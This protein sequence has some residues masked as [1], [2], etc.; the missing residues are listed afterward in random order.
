LAGY[1]HIYKGF[2]VGFAGNYYNKT[3]T[4]TNHFRAGSVEIRYC[5]FINKQNAIRKKHISLYGGFA[6]S[7]YLFNYANVSSSTQSFF[8]VPVFLG[9]QKEFNNRIGCFFEVS[10]NDIGTFKFGIATTLH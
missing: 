3:I 4:S 8:Y 2:H 10:Y 6:T 1:H 5:Y 7:L 9:M